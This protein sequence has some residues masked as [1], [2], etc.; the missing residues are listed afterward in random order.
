MPPVRHL[1]ETEANAYNP[2]MIEYVIVGLL[3]LTAIVHILRRIARTA[4]GSDAGC[5]AGCG[6]HG[7]P[8]AQ[9]DRLGKRIDL[10]Q[11]GTTPDQDH[12]KAM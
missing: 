7:S 1:V 3:V 2:S 5:G 9:E 11:L 10:I 12:K 4:S 8:T 6:C